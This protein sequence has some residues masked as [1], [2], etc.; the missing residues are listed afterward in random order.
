MTERFPEW[1]D[2]M[3]EFNKCACNKDLL[4]ETTIEF[5]K[6]LESTEPKT[7][8]EWF[9]CHVEPVPVPNHV[10]IVKKTVDK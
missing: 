2:A 8:E 4:K 9:R 7:L 6:Y 3:R 10:R 1:K 5:Q